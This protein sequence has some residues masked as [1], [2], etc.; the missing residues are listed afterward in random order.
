VCAHDAHGLRAFLTIQSGE[1]LKKMAR[2]TGR[3]GRA[4]NVYLPDDIREAAKRYADEQGTSISQ[5]LAKL[6]RRRLKDAGYLAAK[7]EAA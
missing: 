7:K 3:N 1:L 6:I 2:S 4:T 5:V